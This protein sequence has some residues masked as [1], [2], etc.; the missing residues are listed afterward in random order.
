MSRPDIFRYQTDGSGS[1]GD[2]NKL[3]FG[4]KLAV[5]IVTALDPNTGSLSGHGLKEGF[6]PEEEVVNMQKL[7]PGRVISVSSAD[8]FTPSK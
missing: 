1:G 2:K 7:Y 5:S 6:D 3:P 4:G 8:P